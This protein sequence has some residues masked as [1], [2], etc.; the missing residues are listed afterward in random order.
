M[1]IN[2]YLLI[3]YILSIL[4]VTPLLSSSI[5][6]LRTNFNESIIIYEDLEQLQK[7]IT[8]AKDK[9]NGSNFSSLID[10]YITIWDIKLSF[11]NGEIERSRS[12]LDTLSIKT[13]QFTEILCRKPYYKEIKDCNEKKDC[14]CSTQESLISYLDPKFDNLDF[15]KDDNFYNYFTDVA[16]EV[17]NGNS[18]PIPIKE[19]AHVMT[20]SYKPVKVLL[21]PPN[22]QISSMKYDL[23]S[24]KKYI[25]DYY[26][27]KSR[28]NIIR[29]LEQDFRDNK[30]RKLEFYN[31]YEVGIED[32]NHYFLYKNIPRTPI[33]TSVDKNSLYYKMYLKEDGEVSYRYSFNLKEKKAKKKKTIDRTTTVLI[34]WDS[35]WAMQKW[36][37]LS[38][39]F[40]LFPVLYVDDYANMA[41]FEV[42]D[43]MIS[44]KKELKDIEVSKSISEINLEDFNVS[45]GEVEELI[46]DNQLVKVVKLDYPYESDG[47]ISL[48]FTDKYAD[49]IYQNQSKEL[50]RQRNYLIY[51]IIG[52]IAL[53]ILCI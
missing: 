2:K 51:T 33:S 9:N 15:L 48:D 19:I 42:D 47:T 17:D 45:D 53:L 41:L 5:S 40:L 14:Y 35:S 31:A 16:V 26:F 27:N 38:K 29:D 8:D 50:K 12:L 23:G 4:I 52:S 18:E 22:I 25:I 39:I 30:T 7:A 37:D 11:L 46:G 13:K 43:I 28:E 49:E 36:R 24:S 44:N 1:R 20:P 3:K 21:D 34:R 6:N 10:A 32:S